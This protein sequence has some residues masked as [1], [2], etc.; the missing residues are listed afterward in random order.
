[1][2]FYLTHRPQTIEELD[3]TSV[4]KSLKRLISS[5]N[6]PHALL[7]AGPKG[8]GKTSAAR[9][10]AKVINCEDP[11]AAPCNKCA[12]CVSITQGQNID[13]IELDAA[14][15]RGIDDIRALRE[16]VLLAPAAAKKKVYIIDEAHMLTTE[17]ANAFLKTLEEPPSHVV[18]ILA[19]TDPHRL[20]ATIRSRLTTITFHKATPSEIRR[21][22]ARVIK[23]EN[24]KIDD[25]AIGLIAAAADGSFRD[26]VKLLE[27]LSLQHPKSISTAAVHE[28]LAHAE[29]DAVESFL[30]ALSSAD[31]SAALACIQKLVDQGHSIKHFTDDLIARLRSALL[32]TQDLPGEALSAFP[33]ADLITLLEL[34]LASRAQI[35]TS[36]LDQLPLEIAVLKF[37]RSS[38]PKPSAPSSP[39][40]PK[41]APSSAPTRS[42]DQALDQKCWH[43]I[44]SQ[45]KNKNATIEALLRAAEPLDYDGKSLN[46]GVY[47][48]F[49]KEQLEAAQYRLALEEIAE[50]ILGSPV[51]IRYC[52]TKRSQPAPA[53]ENLSDTKDKDIIQAAKE[54]FGD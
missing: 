19:T 5:G 49:H 47:Y 42:S 36:P 34:L 15:N 3:L 4:R 17:A 45:I 52:L 53:K 32:A 40:P 9:L 39:P 7:F 41:K 23:R 51:S 13:V 27:N 44:M 54:I 29:D 18:F 12:Q 22:L 11:S 2:A 16:S 28:L 30:S 8:T 50:S 35:S 1:M 46:I 6:I 38:T 37:S 21:Q 26:A 10:L 14:S 24:L 33:P 31:P 48:Q 20:P 43:N 25:E